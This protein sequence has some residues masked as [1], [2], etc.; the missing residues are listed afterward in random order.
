[1]SRG[2][3]G[4]RVWRPTSQPHGLRGQRISEASDPGPGIN[5]PWTVIQSLRTSVVMWPGG[6]KVTSNFS[7]SP[8]TCQA[9]SEVIR[10]LEADLCPRA[11]QRVVFTPQ[12]PGGMPQS[13]RDRRDPVLPTGVQVELSVPSV[14]APATIP[15]KFRSCETSG[16]DSQFAGC[17][18]HC[19]GDRHDNDG[20]RHI[21]TG[22]GVV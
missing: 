19:A 20:A 1:M 21:R 22:E 2:A 12:S 18:Q 3:H 9:P 17:S 15:A 4:L 13:V 11:S 10:A 7:K 8:H 6:W 14:P 16:F 5:G